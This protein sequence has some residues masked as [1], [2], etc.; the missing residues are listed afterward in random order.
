MALIAHA[1]HAGT[2]DIAWVLTMVTAS[3]A[4]APIVSGL[5][6][7]LR[8][9][10]CSGGI[11]VV[12]VALSPPFDAKADNLLTVHM[13]QHLLLIFVAAPLLAVGRIESQI[14]LLLPRWGRRRVAMALGR[15]RPER[16]TWGPL[17][18]W[19]VFAAVLWLWHV[20]GAYNLALRNDA[21]HA[22]EH[23]SFLTAGF[24]LWNVVLVATARGRV[25]KPVAAIIV[26][27]TMVHSNALAALL[28]FARETWYQNYVSNVVTS[29]TPLEDQQLA[30]ALMWVGASPVFLCILLWLAYRWLAEAEAGS[31]VLPNRMAKAGVQPGE[32]PSTSQAVQQGN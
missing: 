29:L 13:A 5:G 11:L 22:L 23:A 20:P 25:D 24:L 18:I 17:V 26:F 21:V 31:P 14:A 32:P 3:L 19:L 7:P 2:F 9:L 8:R 4:L 10:A 30:G 1:G 12:A 28:V 6:R 16:L 27:A 15:V